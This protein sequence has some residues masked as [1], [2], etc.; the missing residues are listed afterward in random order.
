MAR[1]RIADTIAERMR[2]EGRDSVLW[3][4]GFLSDQRDL[5]RLANMHP[6]NVI[7]AACNA[8]ERAPDLFEKRMVHA[9]DAR[10]RARVV[11]GF[12]LKEPSH[13]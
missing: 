13:D 10:C 4:D 12:K 5:F 2:A 3:G 9:H 7:E 1:R 6:L 8:L 11:R